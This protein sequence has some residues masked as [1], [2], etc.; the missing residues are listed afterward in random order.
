MTGVIRTARASGRNNRS[1]I[2]TLPRAIADQYGITTGTK[3]E[4]SPY[5]TNGFII[6]V[7]V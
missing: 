7:K 4:I 3:L 2:L 6:Q 1:I 5:M